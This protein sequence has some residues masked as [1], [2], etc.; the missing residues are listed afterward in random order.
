MAKRYGMNTTDAKRRRERLAAQEESA[1]QARLHPNP[2]TPEWGMGLETSTP[3]FDIATAGAGGGL[4][5]ARKVIMR[6]LA[7]ARARRQADNFARQ[8][9]DDAFPFAGTRTRA[10]GEY[11]PD[12]GS[13]PDALSEYKYYL[14]LQRRRRMQGGPVSDVAE[15]GPWDFQ[16]Y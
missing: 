5:M 11:Q 10:G 3:F 4:N 1:Y 16:E 9:D 13:G 6:K 7:Q 8:A 15:Y 2:G 14:D 12:L